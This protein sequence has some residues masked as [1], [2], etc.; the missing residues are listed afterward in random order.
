MSCN[1]STVVDESTQ[2]CIM[3]CN[4][5]KFWQTQRGAVLHEN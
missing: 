4:R 5:N 2:I 3:S 1:R